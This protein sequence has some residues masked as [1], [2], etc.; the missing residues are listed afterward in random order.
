[1]LLQLLQIWIRIDGFL[2]IRIVVDINAYVQMHG[3]LPGCA[4]CSISGISCKSKKLPGMHR[5]TIFQIRRIGFQMCVVI[6]CAGRTANA[7]TPASKLQPSHLLQCAIGHTDYRINAT[8]IP[9]GHQIRALMLAGSAESAGRLP[10]IFI[11]ADDRSRFPC[12]LS[13]LI[14]KCQ[15]KILQFRQ[16]LFIQYF[17]CRYLPDRSQ[18]V[19]KQAVPDYQ[20]QKCDQSDSEYLSFCSNRRILSPFHSFSP[21]RNYFKI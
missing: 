9:D 10:G 19:C 7:D 15:W 16:N 2:F 14:L 17:F 20:Q 8:L 4:F 11:I 3:K 6:I 1:M 13:M 5:H 21:V 18:S 12:S